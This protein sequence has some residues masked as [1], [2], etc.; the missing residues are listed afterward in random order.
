MSAAVG[1]DN[2]EKAS[3]T[4]ARA[5]INYPYP[6]GAVIGDERQKKALSIMFRLEVER[7]SSFGELVADSSECKG[8]AIWC[9]MGEL[10]EGVSIPKQFRA[11]ISCM[12]PPEMIKT[13]RRCMSI[14]RGR[15]RMHLSDD[16]VYLYILGVAP[17]SQGKGI[18]SSLVREK[19]AECD[20]EGCT[21]YL[22]TNSEHNVGYYE[23]FGFSVVKK[24][25][26]EHGAFTTWYMIR[27]PGGNK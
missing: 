8:V 27:N 10:N 25:V 13:L 7:V 20:K 26:E 11:L 18:G 19:L 15:D 3:D 12:R 16:T 1:K 4:L 14:E 22:E 6:G 17:E 9:R 2:L 23:S 5:F 21:V 24:I